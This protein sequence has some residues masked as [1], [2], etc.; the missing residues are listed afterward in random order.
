MTAAINYL[1]GMLYVEVEEWSSGEELLNLCL[2]ELGSFQ[3]NPSC[4]L[5]VLGNFN[6]LGILWANRSQPAKARNFLCKAEK[7]YSD[8]KREME[9][10]PLTMRQL[11]SPKNS[12][13]EEELE[14]GQI[15]MEA[16][17]TITLYYLAQV[18]STLND[19]A[20]SAMYCHITLKRQ[21]RDGKYDEVD[22]ALNAATLSQYFLTKEQ[23]PIARH[24]LACASHVIKLHEEK[25]DNENSE[26][27][28]GTVE[29]LNRRKA[30]IARCWAKYGV[31]LL[32]A[33]K[34]HLL[35]LA[36]ESNQA[37]SIPE[38]SADEEKPHLLFPTLEVTCLEEQVRDSFVLDFADSR[39]VFLNSKKWLEEAKLYYTLND[40]ASDYVQIEQ[41]MSR[42]YS[43][44]I[45]FEDDYDR[46]CKMHKRRV[47][48][49]EAVLKELN[50]QYYLMV[51]RQLMFEIAET[52]SEMMDIK[53]TILQDSNEADPSH[54]S[55]AKI[56]S[57]IGKSVE[58]FSNFID[59]VKDRKTG[60]LPEKLADDVVRPTLIAHFC[61]ARLLSKRSSSDRR[62]AHQNLE[63]SL[64][65]FRFIVDYLTRVP[66]HV[67]HAKTEFEV[68]KEMANLLTMKLQNFTSA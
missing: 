39:Q 32:T 62:V 45:Y 1:Q 4:C 54:H 44:L 9:Q 37:S 51:C 66:E 55:L 13:L 48:I 35:S 50:P 16:L 56:Q 19:A 14:T 8:C 5:V 7:L 21:L 41:E 34:D 25:L 18:Y 61:I 27:V 6:Q 29:T 53:K 60:R 49:L 43:A 2:E 10:A 57:L 59:S 33:S 58:H 46:Q 30:D 68:C 26:D 36:D 47:D 11:F 17:H 38:D 40:H 20:K 64:E 28:D 23:F 65:N 3:L 67:Q 63:N 31:V 12:K 52:Y 24:H 22:W 15:S 42:A